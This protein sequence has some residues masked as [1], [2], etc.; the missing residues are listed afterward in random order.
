MPRRPDPQ[1]IFERADSDSEVLGQRT[2]KTRRQAQRTRGGFSVEFR[3]IGV[4]EPRAKYE[5]DQRTIY[6]NL[7]HPQINRAKLALHDAQ[8]A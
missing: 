8:E 3:S 2:D 6:I 7:D 4:A 5:R 1:P